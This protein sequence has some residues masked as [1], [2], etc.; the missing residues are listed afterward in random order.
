METSSPKGF[1]A[2]LLLALIALLLIGGGA[3]VYVHNKQASQSTVINPSAQATSTANYFEIKEVGLKFKVTNDIKDLR[4][5]IINE[6]NGA[7]YVWFST[8]TL[9][10]IGGKNCNS[11]QAPLGA[12]GVWKKDISG[13][14]MAITYLIKSNDFSV[15][16]GTPQAIC[17]EVKEAQSLQT[18][19]RV[20]LSEA[21][22]TIIRTN[23]AA[24][25][26]ASITVTS[27]NGGEQL[28]VFGTDT[29]FRT[30]WNST[31][32]SG[33]VN[34]YLIADWGV[35]KLGSAPVAQG[36]FSVALG[37]NYQCPGIPRTITAG[38]YKVKLVADTQSPTSDLGVTDSS[39]NYFT[40][41]K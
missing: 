40:I 1:I 26:Q 41:A 35:C 25:D 18:E 12:I 7:T 4:Y 24:T 10:N 21:L 19:Q 14:A 5:S 33:T 27:P 28:S 8:K 6:G 22:K 29:N 38:Q 17:S 11:D 39:D 2:P 15:T 37:S 31:S 9:E 30:T 32:L 3:Y 36:Y 13:G 23:I 34:V 16:Y 20:S